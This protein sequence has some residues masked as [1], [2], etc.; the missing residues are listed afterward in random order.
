MTTKIIN[1]NCLDAMR[2]LPENSVDSILTD[3]PYGLEFMGK[4]WDKLN[5]NVPFKDNEEGGMGGYKHHIRY[6]DNS[7]AMQDWHYNWA[8]EALRVAKPGAHMLAFGG[9]RTHHRL[10]CAIEDAGWEIR[11][12]M[13]WV[14]GQG[15]PKSHNISKAIDKMN[16]AERE[17]VG[18]K[19]CS[20]KGVKLAEERT[21]IGAGAFGQDKIVD[22]TIPATPAAKQWDGWGT[23]LKP[24]WEP[25][26]LCRKPVEGTIAQNVLKWGTGGLNI[27][28]CRVEHNEPIKNMKAQI[29]G[30]DVF[31][32]AGRYSDTTELKQNG[33]FPANLIH[34]GSEEV[35]RLFPNGA[36]RFF[37]CA[38]PSKAERNAG[39]EDMEPV[40]ILG[41][42]TGQD[43]RNV[44]QKVRPA[45]R[46]NDHPTVKPVKLLRYLAR[47]IT[48]P[49]G[50]IL[51]PFAGSGTTG[52]AA[53]AEGFDSILIELEKHYCDIIRSRCK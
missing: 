8:V 47:L 49:N 7:N 6:G 42:D 24:A 10:M 30:H 43:D 37:Y 50:T 20:Q 1:K 9:T 41:R 33:R 12:T 34:D 14:Y 35:V 27:D 18:E 15:F 11:D 22:V 31:G 4:E 25:I 38:K 2:E 45:L 36:S 40:T 28:G 23:G 5:L 19:F 51:D 46:Q 21:P 39:C 17:V 32:Q 52:V 29:T 16:G 44:P 3:P 48:P 13:M 26:V 53:S